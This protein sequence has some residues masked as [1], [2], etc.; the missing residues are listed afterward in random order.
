MVRVQ[1]RKPTGH[2]TAGRLQQ[3]TCRR[4]KEEVRRDEEGGSEAGWILQQHPRGD[5]VDADGVQ[6]EPYVS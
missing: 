5:V 3:A 4:A 1:K 6:E 2:Q